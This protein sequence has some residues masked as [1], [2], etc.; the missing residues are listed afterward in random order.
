MPDTL[1]QP[2]AISPL[3]AGRPS[4]TE[5]V[6]KIYAESFRNQAHLD[7]IVEEAKQIASHAL[8]A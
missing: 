7:A 3:A 1:E 6:C 2:P 5:N 8:D 4:G